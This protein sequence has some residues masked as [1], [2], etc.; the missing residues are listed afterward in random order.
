MLKTKQ[1]MQEKRR[2]FRA[3]SEKARQD[4]LTA[5]EKM[6]Q[7]GTFKPPPGFE[8]ASGGG[9]R[10]TARRAPWALQLRAPRLSLFAGISTSIWQ[11]V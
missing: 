10:P 9:V 6:K 8:L 7:G 4:V 2:Q 3:Q 11:L 1:A 5:F